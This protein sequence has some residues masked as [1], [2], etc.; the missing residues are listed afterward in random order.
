MLALSYGFHPATSTQTGKA[1]AV[2]TTVWTAIGAVLGWPFSAALSIP[3]VIEQ[4][5]L[6][7][8]EIAVG[9]PRES[10]RAKRFGTMM[11]AIAL[12]ATVAVSSRCASKL[13]Y[14]F[15]SIL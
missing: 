12:G 10:L 7:G 15:P 14:R 6:T 9:G 11:W 4:L 3:F 5:F 2:K 8:D 13:I 1:R